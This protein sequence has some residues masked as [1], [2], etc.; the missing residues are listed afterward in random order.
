MMD[1][2]WKTTAAA[3]VQSLHLPAYEDIPDVGLFLEQTVQYINNYYAP[4]TACAITASMISNYVKKGIIA[5]P[6]RR[7]YSREQIAS[8]FF[9]T[10]AKSVVTLEDLQAIFRVQR[11][12]YPPS[13]A[14]NYFCKELENILQ[15]VFGMKDTPDTVG[16]EQTEEKIMLRNI[17]IAAAHRLYLAAYLQALSEETVNE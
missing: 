8:L 10:A 9:I 2:N 13:V 4:L 16:V 17:I 5:Q 6:Q 12:S 14:Y 1:Q 7:R 15:F 3:A 11:R